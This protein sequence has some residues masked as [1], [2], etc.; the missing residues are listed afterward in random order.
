MLGMVLLL[1]EGEKVVVKG[2][3]V[4]VTPTAFD[5]L[6][7]VRE[8]LIEAARTRETVTYGELREELGLPYLVQGMGRLLD[9]VSVDCLRRGEPSLAS[10]VVNASTGEVGAEFDGDPA[11]E[12]ASVLGHER[13]T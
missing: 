2:R 6:P 8:R 13:W 11:A 4:T 7:R 1:R 10:M 12:R 3:V 5:C 9:L